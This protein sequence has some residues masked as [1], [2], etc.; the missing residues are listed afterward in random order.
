[1]TNA[2]SLNE[3]TVKEAS[4]S[5]RE[6]LFSCFDLVKA[7]L[8]Q[9]KKTDQ[10]I[11]SFISVWEKESLELADKQDRLIKKD[12]NIY[13][14]KPLLGIPLAVKDNFCTKGKKTTA[15]SNVLSDYVPPYSATVVERIE[16]AG[17]IILGKTNMDA[18]AHGSSTETSDFFATRN[19]HDLQRAPGGSSGGSAA[20][21]ASHQVL[22]AIGSETA[23]SIRQPAAWCGVVGLKPSYGRVSRWGLMAMASS[24]DSPGPLTKTAEDAALILNVLS[25][26]DQKDATS[27]DFPYFDFRKNLKGSPKELVLGVPRNYFLPEMDKKIILVIKEAINNFKKAGFKVKEVSLLDPRLAMTVYTIIMRAEVSSNLAR[28]DGI[29]FGKS[30]KYFGQEAKRRILVGSHVLSAGY[31]DRYYR[32]AQK[33]RQLILKD[34]ERVFKKVDLLIAPTSPSTALKI[35]EAAKN[36]LFGEMQ[37]ILVEA[38]ALAGLPGISINVGWANKLPVGLQIIAP[39]FREDIMLK[40]AYLYE[41]NISK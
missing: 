40:V 2:K 23:G 28:Y 30:R 25:G 32:Y 41:K 7:C 26:K 33:A 35:G 1:M 31:Y 29:R 39:Q 16:N 6:G 24:T 21:V 34:F 15:S 4:E 11:K 13:I 20:A 5:L 12:K 22:A 14:R 19:P 8:A 10:K 37:D 36:P 3:L 38:S 27:A 17:G 9:I 18:W